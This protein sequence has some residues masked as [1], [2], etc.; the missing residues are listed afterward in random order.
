[1]LA[2]IGTLI[3][4]H[5]GNACGRCKACL[6]SRP[7]LC[8]DRPTAGVEQPHGAFADYVVID[9]DQA[10]AVPPGVEA[11]AAAYA[12][13]LAVALHAL[14]L[15]GVDPGHRIMVSGCGP[16]GAA[17]V[18]AL[19]AQGHDDVVVVEP[20]P[21]VKRG[22]VSMS[23]AWGTASQTDEDVRTEGSPTNRLVSNERGTD[24]ITGMAVQS[25]IPVRVS[26]LG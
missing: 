22:V 6:A 5:P 24:P 19:I 15:A 14:E 18:A 9:S 17:T 4:G 21:A 12:E 20:S 23:H 26:R 10:V 3:V 8:E 7:N 13:P 16:I 25:A 11:R 1:L 2:D